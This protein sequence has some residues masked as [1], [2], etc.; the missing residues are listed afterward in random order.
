MMA[1]QLN[2][3]TGD[4]EMTRDDAIAVIKSHSECT[5][6]PDVSTILTFT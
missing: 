5:M 1:H 3:D 4:V 2:A 6:G